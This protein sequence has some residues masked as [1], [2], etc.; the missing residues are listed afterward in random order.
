MKK[1]F[2]GALAL[3]LVVGSSIVAGPQVEASCAG[4][5]SFQ[6]GCAPPDFD[7]TSFGAIT[8]ANYTGAFW[9]RCSAGGAATAAS[10]TWLSG[11]GGNDS[12]SYTGWL[13]TVAAGT[14]RLNGGWN[15]AGSIDGCILGGD[16]SAAGLCA[17]ATDANA[18]MVS[19][20]S[21]TGDAA[22]VP[23]RSAVAVVR[24]INGTD[25]FDIDSISGNNTTAGCNG[26]CNQTTDGGASWAACPNNASSPF[27]PA[28]SSL[29]FSVQPQ[30]ASSTSTTVTL[31]WT[32]PTIR[33]NFANVAYP[34]A[35]W[36]IYK[37]DSAATPTNFA[38]GSW[39]EVRRVPGSANTATFDFGGAPVNR[40]YF[41]LKP[42][43]DGNGGLNAGA[44]C[45]PGV[46]CNAISANTLDI[47][48]KVGPTSTTFVRPTASA[49]TF[50]D[51]SAVYESLQKITIGFTT[52]DETGVVGFNVY[53]GTGANPVTFTKVTTS[54]M[55]ANGVASTY[56]FTDSSLP[57]QRTYGVFTYKVEAI[58]AA[59]Q[60][61]FEILV[62]VRK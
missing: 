29:G 8:N 16:A 2:V 48:G 33:A 51:T 44:A 46:D 4:G 6:G 11:A 27:R 17:G 32:H 24:Y 23:M 15:S 59:N 37:M 49:G 60:S 12:G 52:T 62:T 43:F 13:V 41:A 50:V 39:T 56:S 20:L 34:I 55:A 18:E 40:W 30:I 7:F 9:A 14:F 58:D 57:R 28:Q 5:G 35:S 1:S 22:T 3:V 42:R 53:R 38:E 54:P 47:A 21:N 26:T 61:Q 25:Y 19:V 36:G 31:T 45:T 10:S